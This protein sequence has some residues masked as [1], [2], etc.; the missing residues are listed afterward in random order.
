[1]TPIRTLLVHPGANY[2]TA[3]VVHGYA[4]ALTRAGHD[5]G[6][7]A[8]NARMQATARYLH[9]LLTAARRNDPSLPSRPTFGDV[10]LKASEDIV[11][12]A[13]RGRVDLVLVVSALFV[14]PSA[15]RLLRAAR[16]PT[17]VIFTESPY[18][19]DEQAVYAELASCC[20]VNDRT[21]VEPLRRVNARTW[22]LPAAY[23]AGFHDA[24]VPPDP[25]IPAHDVV[26][27]GTYFP[28]RLEL[29]AAVDWAGIDLGLYG[30]VEPRVM[31]SRAYKRLAPHFRGGTMDNDQALAYYR[32]AAVALNLNR[33]IEHLGRTRHIMTAESL[34][35]RAY[36]LAA[37]GT[38]QLAEHRAE[39]GDVFG[40]AVPTFT[41]PAELEAL[42][43]LAL[44]EPDWRRACAEQAQRRVAPHSF[45]TRAARVIQDVGAAVLTN[46]LAVG[47][48]AAADD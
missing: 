46:P 48:R 38:F 44:S 1:M 2:S 7:Y 30:H 33:T 35:P 41:T 32:R 25:T 10:S 11:L 16:V 20:W 19:D 12:G 34:N 40:E 28:E 9:N 23:R 29:L 3:D 42:V 39:Y 6:I 8:L 37:V 15:F 45:D 4:E 31:R 21:S 5:V 18:Q 26:F 13:L 24:P 43:R 27:V 14:N 36:E 22:Y 47:R 17:G